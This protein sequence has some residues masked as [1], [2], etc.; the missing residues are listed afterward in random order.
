MR[1]PNISTLLPPRPALGLN[2]TAGTFSQ[3]PHIT[4]RRA[5]LTLGGLFVLPLLNT[6]C[7]ANDS[8]GAQPVPTSRPKAIPPTQ[9]PPLPQASADPPSLY[10]HLPY[11][12]APAAS[13]VPVPPEYAFTAPGETIQVRPEVLKNFKALQQKAQE[14]AGLTLKIHQGFRSQEEQRQLLEHLRKP[15]ETDEDLYKRVAPAGYSE[16][17]TGFAIDVSCIAG[18]CTN[19]GDTLAALAPE[20]GFVVSFPPG[21]GQGIQPEHWHL[22]WQGSPEAKDVFARAILINRGVAL[23]SP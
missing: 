3:A 23:S 11:A 4:R 18:E 19:W 2:R 21:N 20:F 14:Q 13:L 16:H 15:G 8:A 7:G 1:I 22:R 9:A 12:E 6:S 17:H 10:G 5:I